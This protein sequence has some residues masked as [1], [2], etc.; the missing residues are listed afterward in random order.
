MDVY[1]ERK[2]AIRLHESGQ[3]VSHIVRRLKKAVNGFI[4]GLTVI[5]PMVVRM[6]GLKENQKL[7]K[8]SRKKLIKVLSSKLLLPG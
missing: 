7:Q 6:I 4:F 8:S 2:Q 3:K 1:E 5:S